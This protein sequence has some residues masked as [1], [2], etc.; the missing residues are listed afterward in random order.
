MY[1]TVALLT[2]AAVGFKVGWQ[3]LPDG[4][5]EYIIQIEPH[6][7]ET[8]EGGQEIA[9]DIPPSVRGVRSYRIM[10]GTGDPPRELPPQPP[11]LPAGPIVD[12]FALPAG[13]APGSPA[14]GPS[15]RMLSSES[16]SDFNPEDVPRTLPANNSGRPLTGQAANYLEQGVAGPNAEE[17]PAADA[18][19]NADPP[20]MPLTLAVAGMFGSTGGMLYLG[21]IAWDYRRRYRGLL[22]RLIEAGG[23][24][25]RLVDG[26]DSRTG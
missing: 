26:P 23:G 24:R 25:L 8:L 22:E 7:L 18:A 20:W 4:G 9:S 14:P 15:D 21:W 10:V 5:V 6:M 3:P 17:P 12:P 13:S 11:E 1:G 2:M 16:P 19:P